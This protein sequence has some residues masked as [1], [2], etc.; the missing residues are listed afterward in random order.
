ER[1]DGRFEDG[2]FWATWNKGRRS[3]LFHPNDANE[4]PQADMLGALASGDMWS[5]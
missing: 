5:I 3:L 2:F 4:P 1:R